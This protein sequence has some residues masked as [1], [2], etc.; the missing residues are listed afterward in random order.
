MILQA[1]YEYYQRKAADPE[2]NIAPRGFERK[3][4]PFIIVVDLEGHFVNLEDTRTGESKEK[5]AKTFL[6]LK[7]KSRTGRNAAETANVFW[8]H[9]GFVLG[10]PKLKDGKKSPEELLEDAHKQN[11]AFVKQVKIL[12]QKYSD[13]AEFHAVSKFYEQKDEIQKVL[14]HENW[15]DCYKIPGCNLS[16]RI[17]G[18]AD[19]VAETND[20]TTEI[21]I[22]S[23]IEI[24]EQKGVIE[25]ICLITGDKAPIAILH[26]TT[27]IPGG[28][29]G[30]KLVGFQKNSGYDSYHKEQGMNATVSRKAEDA[31]T[32]SLNVLLARDSKNKFRI[33][34]TTVVFWAQKQVG[35]ENQFSF[36]FSAPEKDNPD[37]NAREIKAFNSFSHAR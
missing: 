17:S 32:T 36:F 19:I 15:K 25:A 2:S 20:L 11:I 28:K 22:S 12:S 10:Q 16:F 5:R 35:F 31:Y 37:R 8:D 13:N 21:E 24:S 18:K 9:W 30:G 3:E 33:A 1:L 34:E 7:T 6:V 14:D 29:S 27:P 26:S 23:D 4:I